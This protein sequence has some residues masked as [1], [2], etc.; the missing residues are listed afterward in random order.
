MVGF[1]VTTGNGGGHP[2]AVSGRGCPHR[3]DL[4]AG[5]LSVPFIEDV[6]EGHHLQTGFLCGIHIFLNGDEGNTHGRIY[7]RQIPSHF[8][9]GK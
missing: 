7:D 4:L 6:V 8:W 5:L 9:E 1:L 3:F 2:L